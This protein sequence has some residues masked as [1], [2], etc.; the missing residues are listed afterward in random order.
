M[1]MW[2]VR[3]LAFVAAAAALHEADGVGVARG[4]DGNQVLHRRLAGGAGRA[5]LLERLRGVRLV[6]LLDG[7]DGESPG[8]KVVDDLRCKGHPDLGQVPL[9][10]AG[11]LHGLGVAPQ[12]QAAAQQLAEEDGSAGVDRRI[13]LVELLQGPDLLRVEAT[14]SRLMR[15]VEPR[16]GPDQ[17]RDVLFG[18]SAPLTCTPPRGRAGGGH[19]HQSG[20]ENTVIV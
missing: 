2:Q 15:I 14:L 19:V 7:V 17:L 12:L 10:L 1:G 11:E 18:L 6:V 4:H 13:A 9:E 3:T 16:R 20:R 8:Q 5:L